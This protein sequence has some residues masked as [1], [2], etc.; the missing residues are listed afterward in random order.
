[1]P[2]QKGTSGN[3]AG[4]PKGT[5]DRR[6]LVRD[7]LI[8]EAPNLVAKAIQLALEGDVV[9]LKSCLDK[10]VPN[11]R[12]STEVAFNG[13]GR[14]GE[15][16]KGVVDHVGNGKLSLEEG[17]VAMELLAIQAKLE[18]QDSLAERLAVLEEALG[19]N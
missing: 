4:R 6:R 18:E 10:L 3:P 8:P 15:V 17:K 16:G 9:M 1:M 5:S 7:L 14:L 2:F 12:P 11:A 19:V 13:S